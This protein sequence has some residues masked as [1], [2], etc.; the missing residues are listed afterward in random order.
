[1]ATI[2]FQKPTK[3]LINYY[4]NLDKQS[5]EAPRSQRSKLN[6]LKVHEIIDSAIRDAKKT[7]VIS[8]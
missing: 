6:I 5:S 3:F 7:K 8:I 2:E 1:M 4:N